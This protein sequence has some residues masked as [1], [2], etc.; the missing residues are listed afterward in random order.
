MEVVCAPGLVWTFWRRKKPA[1]PTGDETRVFQ[2]VQS[3]HKYVTLA[4]ERKVQSHTSQCDETRLSCGT[5]L[6]I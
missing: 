1:G 2:P 6:F 4:L 5:K 3:V